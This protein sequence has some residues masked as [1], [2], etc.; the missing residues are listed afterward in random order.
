[1]GILLK[2]NKK[3]F[4]IP[5]PRQAE[6]AQGIFMKKLFGLYPELIPA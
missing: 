1:M 6:P 5:L 3:T 2:Y 4:P